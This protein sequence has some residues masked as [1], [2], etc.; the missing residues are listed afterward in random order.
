MTIE[1]NNKNTNECIETSRNIM[2]ISTFRVHLN[3]KSLFYFLFNTA[4]IKHLKIT[5]GGNQ[6]NDRSMPS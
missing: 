5:Q 1:Y 6:G 2:A 4:I 3:L